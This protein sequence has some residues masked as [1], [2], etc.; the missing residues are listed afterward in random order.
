MLGVWFT[1][2]STK[3]RGSNAN[4]NRSAKPPEGKL[5]KNDGPKPYAAAW[6]TDDLDVTCKWCNGM[7][8]FQLFPPSKTAA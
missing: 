1:L 4:P 2:P 3:A 5:V 7:L 8:V 6:T